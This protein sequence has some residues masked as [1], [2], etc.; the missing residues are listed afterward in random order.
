[1]L[2]L[3]PDIPF[4]GDYVPV[5]SFPYT[6]AQSGP[7]D[8]GEVRALYS[9][10]ATWLGRDKQTDQW[11]RPWPD[12]DRH[13]QHMEDDLLKGRTWLGWDRATVAATIT[14]DTREPLTASGGPVWAAH[15]RHE[16]ALYV[17]RVIVRRC[18]ADLGIGAAP[19]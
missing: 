6:L 18:Y 19:L 7:E 9:E 2:A 4:A 15:K 17:R 12:P 13:R 16:T 11:S 8:L 5:R 10:S 1:M 14:L 3:V